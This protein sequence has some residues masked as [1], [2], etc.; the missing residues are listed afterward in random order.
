[1]GLEGEIQTGEKITGKREREREIEIERKVETALSFGL[2]SPG[3]PKSKSL[4]N[5]LWPNGSSPLGRVG[6]VE[7][8][9]TSSQRVKHVLVGRL[10][11]GKGVEVGQGCSFGSEAE[12]RLRNP[13]LRGS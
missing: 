4:G 6:E 3:N 9:K 1:L 12:G 10:G 7:V 5:F 11:M 13:V 2:V 8:R